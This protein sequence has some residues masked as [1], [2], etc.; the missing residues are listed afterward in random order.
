MTDATLPVWGAPAPV[1][2]PKAKQSKRELERQ[3]KFRRDADKPVPWHQNLRTANGAAGRYDYLN[4][5]AL[6]RG[7]RQRL[8]EDPEFE[9]QI[10]ELILDRLMAEL[11]VPTNHSPGQQAPLQRRSK[12]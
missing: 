11:F 4:F 10:L 6:Y 2:T 8:C 12:E 5:E 9:G 1:E 3:E 7:F